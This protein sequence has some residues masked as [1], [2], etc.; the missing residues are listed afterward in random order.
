MIE[1]AEIVLRLQNRQHHLVEVR[2][3]DLAFANKLREVLRVGMAG[4][5]HVHAGRE[6]LVC[7]VWAVLR[8]S[9]G[10]KTADRKC[11]RYDEALETPILAENIG[12]QPMISARWHVVQVHVCAHEAARTSLCCRVK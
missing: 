9:M 3:A 7:S 10:D 6:A 1:E 5:V 11:V 4:H 12:K 8:I 2:L